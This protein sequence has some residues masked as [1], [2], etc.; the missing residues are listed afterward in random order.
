[1][2]DDIGMSERERSS[3]LMASITAENEESR[4]A[5]KKIYIIFIPHLQKQ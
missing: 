4:M 1:M 3:W 2:D 5:N